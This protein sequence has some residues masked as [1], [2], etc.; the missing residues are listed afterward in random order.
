M[1][2]A[3]AVRQLSFTYPDGIL[4]LENVNL[5]I[6][7]GERASIIGPNGAGKSTLLL[8]L[9]GLRAPTSG[10]IRILGKKIDKKSASKLHSQIGIIFQDP[11]DQ[12][13]MPTVEEDVAFGPTNLGLTDSEINRRV[14]EAL[15]ATGLEGFEERAPHHLSVGEKRRVA[16][17]GVLAMSPDVMLLD[18]PTSGLDP[19]GKEEIMQLINALPGT[20]LLVSHDMDLALDFSERIV[21]LR[22]TILFDGAARELFGNEELLSSA[23]LIRPKLL[24]ISQLLREEGIIGAEDMPSSLM[25]LGEILRARNKH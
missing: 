15:K 4:A 7:T 23:G 12:L 18:E 10:E 21:L 3:I 20:I 6:K 17:A 19:K 24:C 8:L 25:K 16:I 14:N 5:T 2:E 13:F 9:G 1:T 22:R 11:D